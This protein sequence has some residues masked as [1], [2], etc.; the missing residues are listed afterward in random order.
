MFP[1]FSCVSWQPNSLQVI[2]LAKNCPNA[3]ITIHQ[4]ITQSFEIWIYAYVSRGKYNL[5]VYFIAQISELLHFLPFLNGHCKLDPSHIIKDFKYGIQSFLLHVVFLSLFSPIRPL[6]VNNYHK[7]LIFGTWFCP[8]LIYT[9]TK[10]KSRETFLF[11]TVQMLAISFCI[12]HRSQ[13]GI[14]TKEWV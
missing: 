5:T 1:F 7:S 6:V 10:K 13:P 4:F 9:E 8:N 2:I 11:T 14:K 12:A 3:L